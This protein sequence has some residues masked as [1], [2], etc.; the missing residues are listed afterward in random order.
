MSEPLLAL[1]DVHFG[2]EAERPVLRGASLTLAAGERLSLRGSNGSGKTT[3]L[4][5]LVG[6][7]RP[8]SGE[9]VAFGRPRREEADFFEVR[10]RAGLLFQDPDDQLFCATVREDVAFGPLNLGRSRDAARE[11]AAKTL[12][13]LGIAELG[14]RVAH[15]LSGGEKRMVALAAVLAMEPE[16]LLLD[17]PTL[18]LDEPA[19]QRL[20]ATLAS[21]PQAMCIVAHDREFLA[22]LATRAV[23]L[24]AGRIVEQ[25]A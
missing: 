19:Q 15:R 21:L 6:L 1:R 12:A 3:V 11:I 7:R 20:V 17:E 9:V 13:R 4:H 2:Y 14:D 23:A 5:L 8:A 10:A 24:E 25:G 18:G 16:V 22:R